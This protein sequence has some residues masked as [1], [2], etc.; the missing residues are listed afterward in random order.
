MIWY[1]D[2]KIF[3]K[4]TSTVYPKNKAK[5]FL[6]QEIEKLNAIW[7]N[8]SK[9]NPLQEVVPS[10]DHRSFSKGRWAVQ[11]GRTLP[12]PT[13]QEPWCI[14]FIES[15]HDLGHILG[16]GTICSR[17]CRVFCTGH[18]LKKVQNSD[19]RDGKVGPIPGATVVMTPTE[20]GM[21]P[22]STP[23]ALSFFIPSGYL[24]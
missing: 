13:F 3:G 8:A 22:F 12:D 5:H 18:T 11:F 10:F 23:C 20:Y 7:L 1:L 9:A 2:C 24:T 16:D 4:Y 14:G 21:W 17:I 6:V 15:I 19:P